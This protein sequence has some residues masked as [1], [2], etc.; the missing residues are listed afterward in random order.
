MINMSLKC[1]KCGVTM[2]RTLHGEEDK[3]G[4]CVTC[5]RKTLNSEQERELEKHGTIGYIAKQ[6]R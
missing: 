2:N 1:V 6:H 4:I 3:A 5:S